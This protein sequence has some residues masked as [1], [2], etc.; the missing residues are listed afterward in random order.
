M[1]P[2]F[3]SLPQG[4][5]PRVNLVSTRYQHVIERAYHERKIEIL[6]TGCLF[7]CGRLSAVCLDAKHLGAQPCDAGKQSGK[8]LRSC[9][10]PVRYR[11]V[12]FP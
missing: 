7:R 3:G 11:R 5:E 2:L 8:R 10:I 9:G 12:R 4:I 1:Q 6:F